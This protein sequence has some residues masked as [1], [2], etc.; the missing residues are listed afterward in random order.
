MKY[1]SKHS[2]APK[3]PSTN[4][5]TERD[6]KFKMLYLKTNKQ[7]E[8]YTNKMLQYFQKEKVVQEAL[9]KVVE[10]DTGFLKTM[11]ERE[12]FWWAKNKFSIPPCH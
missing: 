6:C 2:S 3:S 9:H 11:T 12:T 5:E 4:N 10:W 1:K 8:T 7:P